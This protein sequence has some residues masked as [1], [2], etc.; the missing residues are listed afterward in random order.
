M[1]ASAPII[2]NSPEYACWHEAGHVEA[3]LRVG[4]RVTEVELY[5]DPVR[6]YGRTRVERTDAQADEIALGGFGVEYLLYRQ[7]RLLK[8]D[9]TA[10]TEK[11]FID[12]AIANASDDYEGYW[13]HRPL[14]AAMLSEKD[15]DWNF[16]NE[17]IGRAK[18]RIDLSVVE[19]IVTALRATDILDEEAV[20]AALAI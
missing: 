15:R 6:S 20:K 1:T 4:A 5:R 16:M 18:A 19:R 2:F 11:E 10:P 9:G 12:H 17:A 13:K 3:A 14:Q 8:E 7:D